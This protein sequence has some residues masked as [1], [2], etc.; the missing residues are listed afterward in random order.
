MGCRGLELLLPSSSNFSQDKGQ[1]QTISKAQGPGGPQGLKL[2]SGMSTQLGPPESLSE[3][4]YSHQEL[5][6]LG[7]H[8]RF[9]KTNLKHF[10]I[11]SDNNIKWNEKQISMHLYNIE[12][13][14]HTFYS[15][16]CL[17]LAPISPSCLISMATFETNSSS[18]P[19]SSFTREYMW[20]SAQNDTSQWP[21]ND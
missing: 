19:P 5:P 15:L 4:P 10:S 17:S 11:L 20:R 12:E 21:G 6:F 16:E 7:R 13:A 18:L 14:S 1:R 9:L 2:L 8:F 3:A